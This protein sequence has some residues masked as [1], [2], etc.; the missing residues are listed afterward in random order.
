MRVAVQKASTDLTHPTD[1]RRILSFKKMF[2]KANIF[3]VGFDDV[4]KI[5]LDKY[6]FIVISP[7]YSSPTDWHAI[8]PTV[9]PI[10]LLP[11]SVS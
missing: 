7:Q 11:D 10:W 6:D 4:K 8:N 1:R 5:N 9:L 3:L 2:G